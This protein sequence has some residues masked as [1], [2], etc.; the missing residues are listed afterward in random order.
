M[1]ATSC[2]RHNAFDNSF[3]LPHAH[4]K[5]QELYALQNYGSVAVMFSCASGRYPI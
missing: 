5:P 3:L 4:M 1:M 2:T